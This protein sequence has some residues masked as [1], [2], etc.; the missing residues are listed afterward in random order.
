METKTTDKTQQT[1]KDCSK[2]HAGFKHLGMMLIC[3]L[4]PLAAAFALKQFG[5][6]GVASYLVLLLCPI[7]HLFMMRGMLKN[8]AEPQ[9]NIKK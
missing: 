9:A 5:Y 1:E 8:Q 2:G 4:V 7:M 3:C 6:S